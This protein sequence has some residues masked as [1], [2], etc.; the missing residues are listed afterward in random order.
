MTA[1]E[2]I[3]EIFKVNTGPFLFILVAGC[4]CFLL[5]PDVRKDPLLL[6]I[7]AALTRVKRTDKG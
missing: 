3:V 5:P 7:G 1:K 2:I 4:L 6:I